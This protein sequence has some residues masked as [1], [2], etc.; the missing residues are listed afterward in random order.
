MKQILPLLLILLLILTGCSAKNADSPAADAPTDTP[1]TGTFYVQIDVKDYGTIVA[2]L[3][4]DTAPITVANFLFLVDS[5]FYDGLTF[6]RI[7][8]GFMI[9]GGDPNGNGTGGSGYSIKGEFSAN[10]FDT[11]LSHTRGVISMARS[12]SFDSA[13]SQFFIMHAD[14]TYLDTQYAAFGEVVDGMDVVDAIAETQTG[15]NDRPV[16]EQKIKTI[17]VDA[18]GVDYSVE[19]IGG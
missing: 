11:N 12:S 2:E 1:L 16:S 19:K 15:A 7:I 3:Y 14:G 17:R 18:K 8:S 13:G 5:G 9:Q 6:H 10:G 4:A